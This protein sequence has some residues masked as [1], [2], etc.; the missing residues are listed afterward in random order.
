MKKKFKSSVCLFT[1]VNCLK[2]E[3]CWGKKMGKML[4]TKQS[5]SCLTP[6]KIY[7]NNSPWLK[8]WLKRV[9]FYQANRFTY[10]T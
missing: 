8:R 1:L 5:N 9:V 2:K 4:V 7:R 6:L 3:K 10:R